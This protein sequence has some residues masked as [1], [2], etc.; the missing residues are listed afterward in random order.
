MMMMMDVGTRVYFSAKLVGGVD[1]SW[2]PCKVP[3][4]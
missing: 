2:F 3:T 1:F 4:S